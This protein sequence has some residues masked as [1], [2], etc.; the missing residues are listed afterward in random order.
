MFPTLIRAGG[1][2]TLPLQGDIQASG[3]TPSQLTSDIELALSKYFKANGTVS[4][5]IR[6]KNGIEHR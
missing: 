3:R 1:K 2:I 5:V 4:L 6:D